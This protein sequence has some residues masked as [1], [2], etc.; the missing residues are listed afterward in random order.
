ME[1]D[2]VIHDPS[3]LK[4]GMKFQAQLGLHSKFQASQGNIGRPYL[5]IPLLQKKHNGTAS[6]SIFFKR[7]KESH[8]PTPKTVM[9]AIKEA[10]LL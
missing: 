9:Q 2:T 7:L 1:P 5:N 6:L 4:A 3:T 10:A 8:I